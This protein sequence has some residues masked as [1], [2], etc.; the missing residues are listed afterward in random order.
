MKE[1]LVKAVREDALLFGDFTLKSGAKSRYYIDLKRGC[2]RGRN[3]QLFVAG[4]LCELGSEVEGVDAFGGPMSGADPLVAGVLMAL[5]GAGRDL[6]GFLVRPEPKDHGT[7]K[8]VEGRLQEG[9]RVVLI[10][11]VT[12]TGASVLRAVAEVEK[13]GAR[14]V[15]VLAVLDRGLKTKDLFATH[16]LD[17]ASLLTIDDVLNAEEM[18]TS[19]PLT[20]ITIRPQEEHQPWRL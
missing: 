6:P 13:A 9:M 15:K 14:V 20:S 19:P 7:G 10:E 16:G 4:L 12:T 1:M 8:L 5:A 11:D 2:L 17:Y 3:L 18:R